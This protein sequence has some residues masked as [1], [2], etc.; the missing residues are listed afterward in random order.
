MTQDT[1]IKLIGS[2]RKA[3]HDYAIED[4]IE[5]GVILTGT[6]VKALRE[7]RVN[8]RE[9]YAVVA[10]GRAVLHN[11]HIGEYSHGNLMN[12][13]PLRPRGLLLHH[14]EIRTLTGKVQQKGLTLVPLRMYFNRRGIAKIEL[15]L[16]RGQR[17]Y[18]RRETVKQ[19]EAGREM[20]RAM[21]TRQRR[22]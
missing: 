20:E 12:H 17:R 18:D 1:T 7:G 11:C 10:G 15:G 9:A 16:A 5:A 8:L 19:R 22:T 6:E 13:E 4:K 21:K 14:K 2:N 3:F